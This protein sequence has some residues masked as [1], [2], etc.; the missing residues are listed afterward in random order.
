MKYQ[1]LPLTTLLLGAGMAVC[2]PLHADNHPTRGIG[3]YPG[4]PSQTFHPKKTTA[5]TAGNVA[6]L[7]TATASSSFDYNLTAQLATDGILAK[8][9][10]A[11]LTVS[12]KKDRS[13]CGRKRRRLTRTG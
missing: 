11:Q 10:P 3:V 1:R 2:P 6:L 5:K 12:T 4:N 7:C 13:I 8:G 9:M